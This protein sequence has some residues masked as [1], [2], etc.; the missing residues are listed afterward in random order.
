[1]K[2]HA[3]KLYDNNTGKYST[4]LRQTIMEIEREFREAKKEAS[5]YRNK[6]VEDRK[7][8]REKNKDEVKSESKG[9]QKKSKPEPKADD[10][11][12]TSA[13]G[14]SSTDGGVEKRQE[15]T[16]DSD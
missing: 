9:S 13:T 1:M 10:D 11:D 2:S 14:F 5:A 12:D 3:V 15:S 4:E 8:A 16:S 7:E 6:L